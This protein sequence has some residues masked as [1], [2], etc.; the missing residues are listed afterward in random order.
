[1]T[2]VFAPAYLAAAALLVV[3]AVAKLARPEGAAA[4]LAEIRVPR[5]RLVVHAGA[6]AELAVAVAMAVRPGAGG[7]AG[8]VLYLVFCVLVG[9]QLRRGST[10]SCGCLGA[11]DLPPTRMHLGL[12][13]AL[14]AVCAVVRPD[15]LRMLVHHPAG[16]A[17]VLIAAA[18]TAWGAAAALELMP[19]AL[20]AYRRPIS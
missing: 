1:V 9:V 19:P 17:V 8:A 10:R 6:L 11:A 14:A 2:A 5:P 13:V 4:A 15:P 3:S 18:A 12:D 20:G 7:P 16:G